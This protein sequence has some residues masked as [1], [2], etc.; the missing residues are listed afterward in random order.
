MESKRKTVFKN[1]VIE[2]ARKNTNVHGLF[3]NNSIEYQHYQE[4]KEQSFRK[5]TVEDV[6]KTFKSLVKRQQDE[7]VRAIYISGLYRLSDRYKNLEVGSI[8]WHSMDPEARMEHIERF[9]RPTL[10]DQFN[11]PKSSGRKPIDRKQ[12]R[13]PDFESAF[14]WLSKNE[15]ETGKSF[16]FHD[17]NTLEKV[18]YELFFR[19]V[20]PRLVNRCKENCGD[21]L[22]SVDIEDYLVV[23]SRGPISFMNK[24]W[25]QSTA[26]C[27]SI[28]R[29]NALKNTHGVYMMYTTKPS[30]SRK[31]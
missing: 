13:K 7:E 19:S 22:F 27:I 11:K 29:L 23:K 16:T 1:S 10:D 20:V 2:C 31:L 30:L 9:R 28:S 5:G 21:K 17:P 6:A 8:K 18:S 24:Q 3:Y 12:T 25:I 26:P 14:D 15:K 4:K